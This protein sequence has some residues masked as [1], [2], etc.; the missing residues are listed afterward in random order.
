VNC[1][2]FAMIHRHGGYGDACVSRNHQ[3]DTLYTFVDEC[4]F[5]DK[6]EIDLRSGPRKPSSTQSRQ[7]LLP[8][9]TNSNSR[10]R[11]TDGRDEVPPV[12]EVLR[13]LKSQ[14]RNSNF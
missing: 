7:V 14:R 10:T 13:A 2:D 12:I 3:T 11:R 9:S 1:L 5:A 8:I 6:F 4:V